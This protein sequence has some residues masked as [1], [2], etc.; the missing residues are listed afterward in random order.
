MGER[1][2]LRTVMLVMEK[3]VFRGGEAMPWR[4]DLDMLVVEG[5]GEV[6]SERP[7]TLG[8]GADG[9]SERESVEDGNGM[10]G[11]C[12]TSTIW[13]T[14]STGYQENVSKVF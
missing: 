8:I 11:D 6:G 1:R 14:P 12:V 13:A 4:L 2:V 9:M 7:S 10:L 5:H 3:S